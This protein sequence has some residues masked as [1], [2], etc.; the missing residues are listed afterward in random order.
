MPA[1]KPKKTEPCMYKMPLQ[2]PGVP[3]LDQ[4]CCCCS[5]R[6]G[7]TVLAWLAMIGAVLQLI[8]VSYDVSTLVDPSSTHNHT[9]A[10]VTLDHV[11]YAVE[12]EFLV[13]MLV[14][15]VLEMIVT[16]LLLYGIIW[17]RPKFMLPYLMLSLLTL[18]FTFFSTIFYGVIETTFHV[19]LGLV[20]I[21]IGLLVIALLAYFWT[22]IYSYYRQLEETIDVKYQRQVNATTPYCSNEHV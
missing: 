1:T 10:N 14:V 15:L 11:M 13:T 17:R 16:A 21:F 2:L 6:W 3:V 12:Q 18:V 19:A 22:V 9:A 8:F 20:T 5:L 4:C 7:T